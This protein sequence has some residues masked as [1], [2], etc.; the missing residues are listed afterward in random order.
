M[1][2]DRY[3]KIERSKPNAKPN[4]R[5]GKRTSL[6]LGL[7]RLFAKRRHLVVGLT[8]FFALGASIGG[9]LGSRATIEPAQTPAVKADKKA[10][11]PT[12]T[13]KPNMNVRVYAYRTPT[14]KKEKP[15]KTPNPENVTASPPNVEKKPKK[16]AK[17]TESAIRKTAEPSAESKLA[18]APKGEVS[19]ASVRL[20]IVIDDLGIDQKRTRRTIQ[21][22]GPLTMAFLPYGYNLRTLTEEAQ[23]VGH[24]LLVHLPMQPTGTEANPGPNALL[25]NL[26]AE[27]IRN[28]IAWNLSQ[29][30]GFVGI[31]NHM[32]SGFST[33]D[34]GMSI[35]LEEIS[36]RGFFYLDSLT[37]PQSVASKIAS[38]DGLNILVRDVFLDNEPD[39]RRIRDRLTELEKIGRR[40]GHAIGIGHPY[41]ATIATLAAWI[42]TLPDKGIKLVPLS[43]L[44]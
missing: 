37:S 36:E 21:L 38:R 33:W 29:F 16:P 41:D 31:N 8:V 5:S 34:E 20:A 35:V 18:Y 42:A 25:M 19:P 14:S 7:D 30:K 44:R 26:S 43:A 15:G 1:S 23:N 39:E 4:G 17:K 24:E 2:D 6:P 32:G 9:Y 27:E 22:P 28:R 11:Q 13:P 12:T 40:R 3:R 10:M